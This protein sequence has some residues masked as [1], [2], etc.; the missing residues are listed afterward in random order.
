MPVHVLAARIADL[1]QVKTQE[2]GSR[3]LACV[4]LLI[5]VDDEK[6]PLVYKVDPAGHYLSYKAVASGKAEQEAMNFLEKKVNELP[7]LDE[8][9]TIEMAI[10]AMQYVLSTDFKGEEIEI[11]VVSAGKPL[12]VLGHEEIEDRLNAISERND[13]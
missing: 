9:L 4:M 8:A 11:G 3:A 6:G 5:G 13:S 1:C 7:L 10:S 12:R 2:A